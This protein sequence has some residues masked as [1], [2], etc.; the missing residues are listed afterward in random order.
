MR[1]QIQDRM[2]EPHEQEP[3]SDLQPDFN[4]SVPHVNR[5]MGHQVS[6]VTNSLSAEQG[7]T[8]ISLLQGIQQ[9]VQRVEENV[10][11]VEER[12]EQAERKIQKLEK[13][14]EQSEG[15]VERIELN[16]Q[17]NRQG[18]AEYVKHRLQQ[19]AGIFERN[20]QQLKQ[21]VV[22]VEEKIEQTGQ[23]LQHLEQMIE[24]V[25]V[26]VKQTRQDIHLTHPVIRPRTTHEDEELRYQ[27]GFI[28]ANPPSPHSRRE[29]A[30]G[31]RQAA[32]TYFRPP[33]PPEHATYGQR[34]PQ[35]VRFL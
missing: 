5:D 15:K 32:A 18:L 25:K 34:N 10:K 22:R 12:V 7:D 11:R 21:K 2:G 20:L 33:A 27:H 14:V 1:R 16:S 13:K 17:R 4:Q 23:S 30:R 31:Q 29:L 19:F 28:P 8:I 35:V 6:N 9:T 3:N 24:R 26:E